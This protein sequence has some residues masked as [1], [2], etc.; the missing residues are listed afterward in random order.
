MGESWDKRAVCVIMCHAGA[1]KK[2]KRHL[3]PIDGGRWL[4]TYNNLETSGLVPV[5]GGGVS[6][7]I[8]PLVSFALL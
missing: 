7:I 1:K 8:F 6:W 4:S 2:E 5:R 3:P